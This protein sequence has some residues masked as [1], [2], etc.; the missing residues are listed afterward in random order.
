[1]AKKIKK[2]E[3]Y[4]ENVVDDV[5]YPT[6]DSAWIAQINTTKCGNKKLFPFQS[7][8]VENAVKSLYLYYENFIS[9]PKKFDKD[10]SNKKLYKLCCGKGMNP[11][12]CDVDP[13]KDYRKFN[14]FEPYYSQNVKGVIESFNFFNRMCFWMATGS[15]KTVLLVKMIEIMDKL[16]DC[17]LIPKRDIMILFPTDKILGQ[18]S[19]EV[20]DYNKTFPSKSIKVYSLKNDY[21]TNKY[22]PP[23]IPEI[24]VYAYRSD[25]LSEKDS[26]KRVSL[27]T[28]DNNGEWYVFVDEAHK[29]NN[30][31][32]KI[33][34]AVTLLSRN[35]FLFNFSA[36]FTDNIDYATTCKN[37]N[38][39]RFISDGYGKNVYL[40]ESTFSIKSD[41]ESDLTTNEKQKQ[42]LKSLIMLTLIKLEKNGTTLYHHPL[43]VTFVNRIGK[44]DSDLD[45]F[46]EEL[47]KIIKGLVTP[48]TF[49][50]AKKELFSELTQ[51]TTD[52]QFGS[53]TFNFSPYQTTLANLTIRD[54]LEQCF[55][56]STH[57]TLEIL[58]GKDKE[59][60]F[61]LQVSTSDKPFAL[62]RIGDAGKYVNSKLGSLL[63]KQNVISESY[64]NI[65]NSPQGDCFNI[66]IGSR[67][68]YEGWD[69]NRPN[70]INYVNI[71]TNAE[72]K[73]L[74]LQSLGRGVRI[75]P[76]KTGTPK[77]EV[78]KR[79]PY[80]D[81]D[82]KTLLETLFVFAT[83]RK[84]IESVM[85]TMESQKTSSNFEERTLQPNTQ[86]NIFDLLIPTY[87][88]GSVIGKVQFKIAQASFD[89]LKL[90]MDSISDSI[91]CLK[92]GMDNSTLTKLR[93]EI[94]KPLTNNTS[95]FFVNDASIIYKSNMD[96]LLQIVIAQLT[97]KDKQVD[98]VKTLGDEIIHFKHIKID[99]NQWSASDLTIFDN[100]IKS[101][102]TPPVSLTILASQ[103]AS[104][105]ITEEEFISLQGGNSTKKMIKDVDL[106][107]LL[108][109]YYVPIILSNK[110]KLDYIKH[111][112]DEESEVDFVNN[113][114]AH[115]NSN[116]NCDWMFSKIDQTI[117]DK[118][119]AMPYFN[120]KLNCY[121]NFFPDFIFWKKQDNNYTITFV[122]PKGTA[123][124]DYQLKV[125]DFEKM[126]TNSGVPKV[127][128]D[129]HNNYDITFR[130]I[131]VYNPKN[132]QVIPVKYSSYW[133]SNDDFS[134]L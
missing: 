104:G 94:S 131:L 103:L 122:D 3:N 24:S 81:S 77:N 49:N 34:D 80:D 113:L 93:N 95:D 118:A 72:S 120:Q 30:D 67:M 46:F 68:F 15:G 114:I 111:I 44:D 69:S 42:V 47:Q 35:G 92:Y 12:I 125:D 124:T 29:G 129:K 43:M 33:K 8:A 128:H 61:A 31:D 50:Y 70:V 2:V 74:I 121:S 51:T 1:M 108:P 83:N 127:F 116:L 86:C 20:D 6:I 71:G 60:E 75:E 56:T 32:S 11:Y 88:E 110:G 21:A 112:I 89:M 101:A 17:G 45:L 65:L 58:Q 100:F 96:R 66:L 63:K 54:V 25:L 91:L 62:F 13:A 109:H 9:N 133:K 84:A 123:H 117:D 38:L 19:I 97:T 39:E 132:L 98:G 40:S 23:L 28:Y 79:L 26:K 7:N 115:I 90:Y 119:I 99:R 53:E 4:L 87:K 10:A 37:Y 126:F 78:R 85:E 134:W 59:S 16:M 14:T 82:K 64:F 76:N 27:D 36:T 48:N 130:L 18:F 57:G 55:N 5:Y 73:K 105:A 52:Y 107:K 22:A 41:K 106:H 102:N